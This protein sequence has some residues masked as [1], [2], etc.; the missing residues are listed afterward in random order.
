MKKTSTLY[1]LLFL[2]ICTLACQKSE[3]SSESRE[4]EVTD[5]QIIILQ[6]AGDTCGEPLVKDLLDVGGVTVWGNIVISNDN[7]NI[8]VQVN[9]TDT[10]MYIT[11]ITAVYGSQ[12]HVSD[13]LT[14]NIFWTACDGPSTFD[15]QK[16]NA[17]QT[18]RTDTL[19]ISN[20]NFQEDSC[21]WIHLSIEL[22]GITG[23]LGCAYASPFESPVFGSAQYQSAFQY[24]RQ[25]CMTD[26][27]VCD[28]LRTQTPGGWGAPPNGNNPG[29]YLHA[30]FANA[31]PTGL[32]VGCYPNNYYV[33][34][35]TAQ[36]ITD[37][38]PTGGEAA[39]LTQNHTNPSDIK[40]VLVGHLVALSLSI[41]FDA[42]DPG[43]GQG[44]KALGDM[45]ISDGDFKGWTVSQFLAKAN[46]VLG[47]CSSDYSAKQVLETAGKINENYVDGDRDEGFLSCTSVPR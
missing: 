33:N 9:S 16:M 10:G 27:T 18:T 25:Q 14:Q 26:T 38:L 46:E 12:Q 21:I 35:T 1:A 43:F 39:V 7:N 30:N 17:P 37:L 8:T 4:N 42:H 29:A 19:Q 3:L 28:T 5:E 45:Y 15:R 32:A 11:K 47:G 6:Q 40:N 23:T 41:G 2:L 31:F 44:S 20:D 36:A 13:L 24:C 22:T 34:L